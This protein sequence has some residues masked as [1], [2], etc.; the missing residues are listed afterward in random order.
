MELVYDSVNEPVTV[1]APADAKPWKEL[2]P[3][4]EGLGSMLGGGI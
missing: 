2:E 1:E 4:L 3:A